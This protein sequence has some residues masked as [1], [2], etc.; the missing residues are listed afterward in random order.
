MRELH[1]TALGACHALFLWG[2]HDNA[3]EVGEHLRATPV[4][5]REA[6]EDGVRQGAAAVLAVVHFR[7]PDLVDV[8][9]VVEGLPK[10]AND[11]GMALLMP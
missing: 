10:N 1:V 4:R 5:F 8:R 9:E 2:V 11:T 6:V 7:F 3:K